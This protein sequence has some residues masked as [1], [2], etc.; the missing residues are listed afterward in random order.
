MRFEGEKFSKEMV[1][2]GTLERLAPVMMTAVTTTLGL[3]PLA[4]GAPLSRGLPPPPPVR[5]SFD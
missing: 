4:P 2:R 5:M 1:V 3:V